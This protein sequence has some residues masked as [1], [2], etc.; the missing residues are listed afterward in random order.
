[1]ELVAEFD[2]GGEEGAGFAHRLVAAAE[3]AGPGAVAVAEQ[4]AGG[5]GVQPSHVRSFGGGG[6]HWLGVVEGFNLLADGEVLAG[7]G[8]VGDPGVGPRRGL[9]RFR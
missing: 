3:V 1:L 5:F 9:V 6:Q 7:D 8:P 2:G 4:A